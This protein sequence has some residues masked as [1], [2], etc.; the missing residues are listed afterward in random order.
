MSKDFIISVDLGGTK[1]LSALINS[2]NQIV[3]RVKI[4]TDVKK[5]EESL[6]KSILKS[7]NQLIL[8]NQI[9]EKNVK[10]LCLGVPGT[11]NPFTR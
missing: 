3:S 11:V 6:I 7:V 4:P 2:Q 10:A 1:I 9:S 5:G 8:D